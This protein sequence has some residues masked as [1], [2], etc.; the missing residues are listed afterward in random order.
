MHQGPLEDESSAGGSIMNRKQPDGGWVVHLHLR[1]GGEL[2]S[3]DNRHTQCDDRRPERE[4]VVTECDREHRY[5]PVVPVNLNRLGEI[6]LW[7]RATCQKRSMLYATRKWR[8]AKGA[9]LHALA[10]VPQ[11]EELL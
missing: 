7:S 6:V 11:K 10:D 1:D 9:Y 8:I 2:H 4:V 5:N 3:H